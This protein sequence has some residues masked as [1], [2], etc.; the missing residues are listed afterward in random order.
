METRLRDG[1]SEADSAGGELI[2]AHRFDYAIRDFSSTATRRKL[3]LGL[4]ALPFISAN[5]DA[6]AR[7]RR[8]K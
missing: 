2:E 8:G 7:Q 4:A 6:E 3:L 5:D 1:R